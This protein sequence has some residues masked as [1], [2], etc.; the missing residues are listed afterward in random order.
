MPRAAPSCRSSSRWAKPSRFDWSEEGLVIG[1]VWRKLLVAHLKLCA[2]PSLCAGG[3]PEPGPRDAVR[4]PHAELCGTGRHSRRGIYDNMKT[5]VDKVKKGKGRRSMPALR[6]CARTT[7]STPISATSRRAGRKASSRKNVQDSRR[8][9]WQEAGRLRFGSFVEL[10]AWLLARCQALWQEIRHP[11]VRAFGGRDARARTGAADADGDGV[12]RLRGR[13][14]ARLQ[15]LP[16]E[17]GPQ[18][19]LGALRAGPAG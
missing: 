7:C 10:N 17:R 6:R 1:G 5:A 8:R 14:R 18:P 4:R 19:L 3:L 9:I 16:G 2:K 11:G 12:R 13:T 15:H